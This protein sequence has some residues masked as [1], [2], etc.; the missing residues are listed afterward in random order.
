[1][2]ILMIRPGALGDTLLTFPVIQ[3][4][5]RSFSDPH[6][7]LVG[8]PLVL[9]LAREF[10]LVEAREDYGDRRWS[11]LFSSKGIVTPALRAFFQSCDLAIA[12]MHDP[13]G[14]VAQ[15]MA[16][17]GA[18]R[19]IVAPGQPAPNPAQ[20][21]TAY[22]AQTLGISVSPNDALLSSR[23][24][25]R[26]LR[27]TRVLGIHPGSGGMQ[28]CWPPTAFAEL[29]TALW[30][31]N[32]AVRLFAGPAEMTRLPT[33]LHHLAP[34]PQPSQLRILQHAPLVEV[35]RQLQD[36]D[37]YL[38]N[39]SGITHLAGLLGLPTLAL[40][41]PSNPA[42]WQPLGPHVHVLQS[43]PLENLSV[44]TVLTTLQAILANVLEPDL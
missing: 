14:T 28:K 22:L 30:Q 44:S 29:I 9:P 32:V 43:T 18:R 12:W 23:S 24:G 8:N 1:M 15:N 17:A 38:G 2:Q 4:L 11:E 37:G 36:C 35:A 16:R 39:D 27:H 26:P 34:P 13:E 21:V 42:I 41:G 5:R 6:V 19:V 3:A 40:F 31:R 20:H 7:T 10:A 25:A 33:I